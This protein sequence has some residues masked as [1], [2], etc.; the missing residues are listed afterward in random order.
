MVVV[1]DTVK[2]PVIVPP[3]DDRKFKMTFSP[4]EVKTAC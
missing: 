4:L 1:P 2:V 3:D